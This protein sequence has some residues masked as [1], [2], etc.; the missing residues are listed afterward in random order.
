MRKIKELISY[1]NFMSQEDTIVNNCLLSC[2]SVSK[3][4]SLVPPIA[5]LHKTE[6]KS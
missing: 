6:H 4:V 2:C 3:N 1:K 5:V